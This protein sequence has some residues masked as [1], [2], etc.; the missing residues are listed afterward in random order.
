[1]VVAP[2]VVRHFR[3][4]ADQAGHLADSFPGHR[5]GDKR[6]SSEAQRPGFDNWRDSP[7]DPGMAEPLQ[8]FQKHGFRD[9]EPACQ[10]FPWPGNERDLLLECIE[11][12]DVEGIRLGWSVHDS[13]PARRGT[14]GPRSIGLLLS[15]PASQ[16]RHTSAGK[17][18]PFPGMPG[19]GSR[20]I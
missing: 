3:V 11:D 7:Q 9:A 6:G 13:P 18:L 1:M 20:R 8:P 17:P 19:H 15:P 4:F 5:H 2:E 10:I 12:A 16:G 14:R